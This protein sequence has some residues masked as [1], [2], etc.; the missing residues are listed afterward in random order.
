MNQSRNRITTIIIATAVVTFALFVFG[1][2]IVLKAEID[3]SNIFAYFV[4]SLVFGGV[5]GLLGKLRSQIPLYVYLVSLA[6]GFVYMISTF[7]RG[8]DGWADLVGLLSLFMI[9]GIG[10][11][12]ALLVQMVIYFRARKQ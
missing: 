5:A 1:I 6:I 4:T 3:I 11:A 7:A 8:L 9:A 12:T 10:L 2:K